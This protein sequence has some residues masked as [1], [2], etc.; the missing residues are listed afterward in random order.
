M[1]Q[2]P[3]TVRTSTCITYCPLSKSQ[4][5]INAIRDQ[6]LE[7]TRAWRK[8]LKHSTSLVLRLSR[9][10]ETLSPW[11]FCGVAPMVDEL[12]QS[13]HIYV[14]C[15]LPFLHVGEQEL[16]SITSFLYMPWSY[17]VPPLTGMSRMWNIKSSCY[18]VCGTNDLQSP[19]TFHF[20]TERS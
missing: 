10:N 12:D 3:S 1:I 6:Y 13:S 19:Q 11:R 16:V 20:S 9:S 2:P 17:K 7:V 4:L 5:G 18:F 14:L 8:L 15:S